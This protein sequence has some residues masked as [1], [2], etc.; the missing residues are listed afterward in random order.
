MARAREE[1]KEFL[2]AV[3]QDETMKERQTKVY[4]QRNL[5]MIEFFMRKK[6]AV[7]PS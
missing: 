2:Q 5:E 1:K 4:F 3:P 6:L 7:S